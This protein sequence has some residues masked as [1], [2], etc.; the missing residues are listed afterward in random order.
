MKTFIFQ[1]FLEEITS[2]IITSVTIVNIYCKDL[3]LSK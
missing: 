1:N 3:K 2:L